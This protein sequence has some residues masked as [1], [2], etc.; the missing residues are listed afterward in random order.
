MASCS[1]RSFLPGA[2]GKGCPFGH[3]HTANISRTIHYVLFVQ[4]SSSGLLTVL[5]T[6]CRSMPADKL[7]WA[8]KKLRCEDSSLS[9]LSYWSA[10]A[11]DVPSHHLL[12]TKC[13]RRDRVWRTYAPWCVPW[14]YKLSTFSIFAFYS[15]NVGA[16]LDLL[17]VQRRSYKNLEHDWK[18]VETLPS[19]VAATL[20][21][22]LQILSYCSMLVINRRI[23]RTWCG[24]GQLRAELILHT[25]ALGTVVRVVH[26]FVLTCSLWAYCSSLYGAPVL[27]TDLRA[28]AALVLAGMSAE[29][30]TY[31]EGVSHIDRGYEQLD[32]KLRL[33]G[34]S[35]RRLPHLPTELTQ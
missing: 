26:F 11:T 8:A 6:S 21:G 14:P 31:V 3:V 17:M 9:R 30:T 4:H 15:Q 25:S 18:L 23:L 7:F 24:H 32:K 27:A 22:N 2:I 29:G 10:T 20:A 1:V 28:G 34:A 13:S 12:W 19:S 35:V 16:Y 5:L 33:L